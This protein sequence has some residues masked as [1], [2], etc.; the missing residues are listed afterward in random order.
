MIDLGDFD[1][2][3]VFFEWR[4]LGED[5]WIATE[6]QTLDDPGDFTT[7]I[8]GLEPGTTYEFR[9]VAVANG[10][11]YEGT[12]VSFTKAEAGVPSI[13]TQPA[14]DVNGSTATLNAELLDLGE[15]DTADVFFEWRE[16]GADEW[17]ATEPQTV[18]E[19]GEFSAEIEGLES[20]STYEFRAVMVANG[21]QFLGATLSFTK[22]GPDELDVETRPATDIN[23]ST[24]TL[25]G[26]L[27]ELG[28]FDSVDVFFE[29]REV[30]AD[31]WN[32]TE[33]QTLDEPGDF[34]AEIEGL[35]P[36]ST[37]EFRAVA[38]SDGTRDEGAI[39][40]FT[41]AEIGAPIVETQMATDVNGSTATLNAELI[42]L[43]EFDTVDVF[44]EWREVGADDWITTETQTLD[45]PGDFSTEIAGLEPGNTYE[46]RAV[47]VA[48]GERYEGTIVSFTKAEVG[49]PSVETQ[50]ATD[51][52]GSTATLNAE[53]IDLGDFD[54]VDVLFEWREV[55]MDD[56]IATG[57]QTLGEPGE[58]STEI[59]GLELGSTYEFRAVV[60]ANGE[61]FLGATLSFTKFGPAALDVETRPAT[62][63]NGS[64]ATLNGELL[65]L[66][67]AA[68]ATVFFLY[69]VKG[70][71]V[72]TFTD[73]AALTEP[74]PFSATAMNLET[75]TTYEFQAVAQVG[76]T[77][78]Y[79]S[80]LE[81]T[82]EPD[83][84]DKKK[85]KRE[86]K[87]AKREYE[88]CKKKYEKGNVNKKQLKKK[89]HA[90][91]R[92]KREYE[93]Y[94]QKCKNAS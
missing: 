81:F 35:Q 86:Y 39:L 30:G 38:V 15:F 88:K 22:F 41:K 58:F 61:R 34:S 3:D 65:E 9:A 64:T 49:A 25:N 47:A 93:E 91:E 14:T 10:E 27:I 16:V 55:G 66:E 85:K 7:E 17:I 76:D 83:K 45:A 62:D 77:V 90:Y 67:G 29:W 24:A 51:I 92:A 46:F 44:F 74:G 94:K 72:W 32:T 21:E 80:I 87:R 11:R 19:P 78:V 36:G 73:E 1:T 4:E 48:D 2:V 5:E 71:A 23:G 40:S 82:K 18:D 70:T 43:G 12:I 89:R 50:P 60:V 69:R 6:T 54:T 59:A 56:W 42:D 13:E 84:K 28:D 20:G 75:G 79:G 26:E 37:Y 52:N 33:T 31:E 63:I 53:L 8:A 57:S 68:E